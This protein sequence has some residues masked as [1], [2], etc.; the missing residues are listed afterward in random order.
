MSQ[1][2]VT[3][4]PSGRPP[5]LRAAAT[6]YVTRIAF[7][8]LSFVSVLVTARVLG[9]EGR[10]NIAF[11]MTAAYLTSQLA[12]F[13]IFQADANIAA[14]EP[15]L[16]RSLAGTSVWL[17]V[18]FGLI[19]AAVVALLIVA[20]PDIGG[21]SAPEDLALVLALLPILVLQ[22][23]LDQLLRA[24]YHVTLSNL[25]ALA[26]PV[27]NVLAV[28]VMAATG[29]LTVTTAIAAWMA[30]QIASTLVLGV[31]VL[32]RLDGFGRFDPGL[33]RRMLRFG[34]KAY[35][36]R[37]LLLGNYRMDTWLLGGIAGATQVGQYS[38]AV[39]WMEM[40]FFLPTAVTL[41]QRPDLVRASPVSAAHN[42]A[43]AA[44][45]TI[46]VTTGLAAGMII[47]A[48]FLCVTVFGEEFRDSIAMMRIL[49]FGAF[50]IIVLKILG[51]ALT[52]QRK[53]MLETA[54]AAAAFVV[55]LG[56]DIALIPSHGGL[57]AS[58]ASAIG[59]SVGGIAMALIFARALDGRMRDLIPRVQDV[60]WLAKRLR[61]A[62]RP[63]GSQTTPHS[64]GRRPDAE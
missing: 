58:I 54:G 43:L 38:I 4:P 27:V 29:T 42:S 18:I 22:P 7:A 52:A 6:T 59:Y 62:P 63:D 16:T 51:N 49:V 48:P 39:A 8:V 37:V 60:H 13:G 12:T 10:G 46:L 23:C 45:G 26:L 2:G 28:G 9:A 19:A 47:F 55:I 11:V 61:P 5:L 15:H 41:A 35:L 64:G 40:L 50:G 57:G 24:H 32:R 53:P 36:G 17:S 44:R 30:G 21:G 34:I 33:A 31:G 20:F 14:R 1:T 56:L 25:G 3:S